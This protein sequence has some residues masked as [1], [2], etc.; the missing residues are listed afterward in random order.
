[1]GPPKSFCSTEAVPPVVANLFSVPLDRARDSE[2]GSLNVANS[3]CG[4]LF[5]PQWSATSITETQWYAVHTRWQHEKFVI[6][7]LERSG[8]E[9][10]LPSIREVHRWSDREKLVW[11]PL[12]SCYAFVRMQ[13]SPELWYKVMQTSGVLGFVGVRGKGI[14]IP[15][16]QI[17]NLRA[18]LGSDVPYTPCPF[19]RIGQRVRISGGALD[20]IE[21]L[22]TAQNGDRTLIVSVEPIQRSIAVR[23]GRYRVEAI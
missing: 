19:L 22:L 21:G 23:I 14:P 10:F 2:G 1:M 8:I 11:L 12:F 15:E 17:K 3:N 13:L 5:E 7:Q 9:T 20:G 16:S 6:K 18:L 4:P